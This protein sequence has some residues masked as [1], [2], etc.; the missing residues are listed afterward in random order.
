MNPASPAHYQIHHYPT[1]WIDVWHCAHK[2]R[3]ARLTLRPI[4]P[5]DQAGL[6]QMVDGLST[7]SRHERFHG[8]I[9]HLSAQ[10][11]SRMTE[12]D[13]QQHMAFVV[14]HRCGRL[15]E[16]IVAEARYAIAG[17]ASPDGQAAAEFALSVRDDWQGCGI[18][19]RAM[20][21]LLVAAREHSL[22]WLHGEVIADNTA[23]LGLMRRCQFIC[24]PCTEDT[25]LV[26]VER[27]LSLS[28]PLP[29]P[30]D[31][32]NKTGSKAGPSSAASSSSWLTRWQ[33]SSL[34]SIWGTR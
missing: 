24:T 3:G 7:K 23:M 2:H 28:P 9:K 13:Y 8:G 29:W 34:M 18:G 30:Q 4:L 21:A 27:S 16:E 11:L 10:W 20:C 6:A 15:D 25:Q 33:A 12:L 14:T 22:S 19:L 5:Q 32:I 1:E 17:S 31:T 26:H